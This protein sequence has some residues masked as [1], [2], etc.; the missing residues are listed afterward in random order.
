M[1]ATCHREEF[2]GRVESV[3]VIC[4]MDENAVAAIAIFLTGQRIQRPNNDTEY[5]LPHPHSSLDGN[6]SILPGRY[7]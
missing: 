4:T 6:W 1:F 2:H 5:V 7:D 3:P